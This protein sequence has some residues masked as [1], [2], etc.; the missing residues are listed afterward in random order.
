MLNNSSQ[1]K[2]KW[3]VII[4]TVGCALQLS[5]I[6]LVIRNL[7][8]H[9]NISVVKITQYFWTKKRIYPEIN[10]TFFQDTPFFFHWK[11]S[12]NIWLHFFLFALFSRKWLCFVTHMKSFHWVIFTVHFF[13][14]FLWNKKSILKGSSGKNGKPRAKKPHR[15]QREGSTITPAAAKRELLNFMNANELFPVNFYLTKSSLFGAWR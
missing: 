1:K 9:S 15:V 8:I 7:G 6:V 3:H 11:N 4:C 5:K 12:K 13:R 14:F 2:F 10:C